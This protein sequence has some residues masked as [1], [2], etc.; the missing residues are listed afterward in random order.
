MQEF[1]STYGFY[2]FLAAIIV[3]A[4]AALA[5]SLRRRRD[6][7]R[8]L[9]ALNRALEMSNRR[10]AE[11]SQA[12]ENR[13]ERLRDTL[14]ERMEELRASNDLR[15]EQLRHEVSGRLD[16]R[17]GDSFR[18]V[19]EQ[20]AR[21]DKGLGEMR[22]LA[23]SVGDLTKIMTNS[24]A[25]GAWG[26]TQL[27]TL[28]EDMLSPGQYLENAAVVPG[29]T[30]RVEFAIVM[31]DSTG[32]STLMAVDSKFPVETYVRLSENGPDTAFERRV[33]DEAKR[34][35]GKYIK[36]PHTVEFAVMFL[37]AESLYAEVARR[38]GLVERI[39]NEYHV[40]V[41]GPCTFAALLTS[42]RIGFRSVTIE[43]RG[44]EVMALLQG[45]QDEFAK[46]ADTVARAGQRARQLEDELNAVEV[47]ARAVVRKMRDIA[48]E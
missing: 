46:Y 23:G 28:I 37:P 10:T 24:R 35:S 30:E 3:L 38:R 32:E 44:A 33:L 36:P 27:R 9:A 26:E 13:Q 48:E 21:V 45:V 47:R 8:Q 16:A 41:S 6:M 31:P 12:M 34:I 22:N 4:A 1:L 39:Q 29:S 17:L 40:L 19:N 2:I 43:R 20:L 25:R 7:D 18:T 42:L 11:L 14:D 5:A 15:F